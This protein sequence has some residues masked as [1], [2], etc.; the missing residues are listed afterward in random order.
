MDRDPYDIAI[1]QI[2]EGANGDMRLALTAIPATASSRATRNAW[3]RRAA[4]PP[5]AASTPLRVR[6]LAAAVLIGLTFA[7]SD[8]DP[9]APTAG[10]P[11]LDSSVWALAVVVS[12]DA[13]EV[14][15]T[16]FVAL[17]CGASGG[18]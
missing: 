12:Q 4:R 15:H 6:A 2:L 8:V 9:P 1:D 11:D 7:L 13:H 16:A 17:L 14:G 5:I 18:V 3:R 10:G